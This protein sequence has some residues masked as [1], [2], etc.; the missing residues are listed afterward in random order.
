MIDHVR[1]TLTVNLMDL[2][3][4]ETRE[5][6]DKYAIYYDNPAKISDPPPWW[7][8][9]E[10]QWFENNYSCDCNR[11]HFWEEAGGMTNRETH[12]KDSSRDTVCGEPRIRAK[13]TLPELGEVSDWPDDEQERLAMA[14]ELKRERAELFAKWDEEERKDAR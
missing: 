11:W 1:Q 7:Q 8:T 2:Y 10:F 14:E 12:L 4:G 5:Y 6:Q 3:T 13:M 9:A